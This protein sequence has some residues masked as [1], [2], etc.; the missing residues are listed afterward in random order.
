MADGEI[1]SDTPQST[2]KYLTNKYILFCETSFLSQSQN[3]QYFDEHMSINK[4]FCQCEIIKYIVIG[5]HD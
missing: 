1:V 5:V 4:C 3:T 2:R